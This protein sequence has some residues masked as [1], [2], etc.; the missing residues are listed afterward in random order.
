MIRDCFAEITENPVFGKN[1]GRKLQ[2]FQ[3]AAIDLATEYALVQQY[4]RIFNSPSLL[5]LEIK[6]LWPKHD[7]K[8]LVEAFFEDLKELNNYYPSKENS[9]AARDAQCNRLWTNYLKYK[10]EN[11]KKAPIKKSKSNKSRTSKERLLRL[12]KKI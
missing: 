5:I 11:M 8:K 2:A 1:F 7:T 10:P 6:Q 3:N 4:I 12:G 9:P